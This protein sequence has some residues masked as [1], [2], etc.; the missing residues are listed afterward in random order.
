MRSWSTRVFHI[1]LTALPLAA[2]WVCGTMVKLA[3]LVQ[4]AFIEGFE[5]GRKL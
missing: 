3:V 4:A 1:A 5:V 2:G